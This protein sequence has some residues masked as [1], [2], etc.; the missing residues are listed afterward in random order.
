M[1]FRSRPLSQSSLFSR[2][3]RLSVLLVGSVFLVIAGRIGFLTMAR[4]EEHARA[5]ERNLGVTERIDAPRGNVFDRNGHPLAINRKAYSVSYSRRGSSAEEVHETLRRLGE[6]LGQNLLDRKDEILT[7]SRWE[8]H[9]LARRL[10]HIDVVPILERQA[11]F[12]GARVQDDFRREYPRGTAFAHVVGYMGKITKE[13]GD[14]F[15]RPIYMP[16]DYVGRAGLERQ[17]EEALVGKA[18]TR[19]KT[20]NSRGVLLEDPVVQQ[21]ARAGEDLHLT[22]DAGLHEHATALLGTESG[23]VV[24]MDVETGELLV[25]ASVP[26]FDPDQPWLQELGGRPVSHLNRAFR[27]AYPPGSTF[28]LMTASAA[29]RSGWT[30]N[31]S[32]TCSGNFHWP[33]WDRPF[34]CDVRYGHGTV[35]TVRSIQASCNVFYYEAGYRLGADALLAEA[36]RYGYGEV[37]GIDLPGERAGSFAAEGALRGGELLNFSIGQGAFLA[38]PLQIAVAFAAIANGGTLV[39]PHVVQEIRSADGAGVQYV[40]PAPRGDIGLSG[41]QRDVLVE[42]L[43]RAVNQQGGTAYRAGFPRQWEFCGKTGTAEVGQ[44]KVDAWFAGFLPRSAPRYVVVAHVERADGHGGDIAAPIVRDLVARWLGED[45][46]VEPEIVQVT[47]GDAES[48]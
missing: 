48:L 36:Q 45:L 30:R 21:P 6:L 2:R 26:T 39:T 12:P 19:R 31:S 44:G 27:G 18:G 34:W 7:T 1:E 9:N 10:S 32:V 46:G 40:R 20:V 8:R 17:Y 29:L 23:S 15:A 42:G 41:E 3:R 35:D 28:K 24:M 4:G 33:G 37:T 5:A 43:Y 25:L 22:L 11:E 16:D 14:R 38:T 47:D 13:D